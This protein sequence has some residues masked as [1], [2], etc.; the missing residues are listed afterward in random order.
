MDLSI[1]IALYNTEKYIRKCIESIYENGNLDV[2]IFEVIVINDGSTDSSPKI[3]E[4]LQNKY[5][6]LILLHKENGGQSSARNLGFV[7]SK[8]KYIFCLDSDDFIDSA[9]L[10]DALTFVN[11][12]KLDLLPISLK[13]YNENYEPLSISKDNYEGFNQI[14]NGGE[15]LNQ[16]L[17]YGS[18]CRYIY[19]QSIMKEN[20][21]FLTEG[22]YHE[23]EEFVI[24]FIS[25]SN[26]I[27]Y[28]NHLV[29]HQIVRN[30]STTKNDNIAHRIRLLDDLV[31]VILNLK[32]H[33]NHFEK[34]SLEYIG[35]SKKIE[36]L[37]VSFFI[38]MKKDRIF[39]EDRKRLIKKIKG[40]KLF[41]LKLEY[42][43][44]K[45]KLYAIYI[46]FYW[47]IKLY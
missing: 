19:K 22:I 41:P 23:D 31:T 39:V 18:M 9:K 36:Q 6:N 21:L 4:E 15:F 26:R 24:K 33:L 32:Q 5:D 12:N 38:R 35:I 11:A 20:N 44:T 45:F 37:L 46:N 34:E 13:K 30:N 16:Y 8:G 47:S 1:V 14:I 27:S 25:Y 43:K 29:Y 28:Q 2:S 40:S 17:I 42:S 7:Q 3:V 10:V